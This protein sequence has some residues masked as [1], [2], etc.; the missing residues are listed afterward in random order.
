VAAKGKAVAGFKP[1]T[2]EVFY[3]LFV[4]GF[5]KAEAMCLENCVAIAGNA[6]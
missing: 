1:N 6:P 4:D 5:H 3:I 2:G